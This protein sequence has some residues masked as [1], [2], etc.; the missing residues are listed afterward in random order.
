MAWRFISHLNAKERAKVK[1]LASIF[2]AAL[3]L[4]VMIA[5]PSA[6]AVGDENIA[7]HSRNLI[8]GDAAALKKALEALTERGAPD[9]AAALALAMRYRRS[10]HSELQEAFQKVTGQ[11]VHDWTEAFLW[12]E[13][14]SEIKPHE[15]FRPMKLEIFRRIDEGFLRF[16][17]DDK[18]LPENMDI[19]L[20]EITWG[21]V[22]V[23]GIPSLDHPNM[24]AASEADYLLDDDLVFGVEINGDS[25]AYPLR[26]MGWHE[27]FN[28]CPRHRWALILG[29]SRC[30]PPRSRPPSRASA[31]RWSRRSPS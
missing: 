22:A 19:R 3:A 24:I 30:S 21:G 29:S 4:S 1:P 31:L 14:H 7:A 9:V 11:E 20:E 25:R 12:Q 27:M 16:L 17:G 28:R 13:A 5:A 18:S 2:S 15:S 26:I 10:G 23:D 6:A 8:L